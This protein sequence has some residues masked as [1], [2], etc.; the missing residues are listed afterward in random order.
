MAPHLLVKARGR[1]QAIYSG[2]AFSPFFSRTFLV[3]LLSE[4]VSTPAVR[5]GTRKK[6]AEKAARIYFQERFRSREVRG[7]GARTKVKEAFQPPTARTARPKAGQHDRLSFRCRRSPM[8]VV[9]L[10]SLVLRGIHDACNVVPGLARNGSNEA[11]GRTPTGPLSLT[12][13][14]FVG[15]PQAST[16]TGMR[17]GGAEGAACAARAGLPGSPAGVPVSRSPARSAGRAILSGWSPSGRGVRSAAWC[18]AS[19]ARPVQASPGAMLP[20]RPGAFTRGPLPAGCEKQ[21]ARRGTG[22]HAE[23]GLA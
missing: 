12:R 7:P 21:P 11:D 3:V 19:I 5:A 9:H 17:Q 13:H 22:K 10:E 18:A 20:G 2:P 23:V 8:A 1:R 14:R 15:Y 4:E 16:D 6:A